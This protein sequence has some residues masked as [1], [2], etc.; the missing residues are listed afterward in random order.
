VSDEPQFDEYDHALIF[1]MVVTVLFGI[2]G[3]VVVGWAIA[4]ELGWMA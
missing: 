3:L 1:S 2:G 4:I